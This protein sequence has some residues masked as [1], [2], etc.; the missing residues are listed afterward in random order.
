[1]RLA[2]EARLALQRDAPNAE[3]LLGSVP[4]TLRREPGL[5]L[6]HARWLRRA[7]RTTDALALWQRAG[8]AAQRD[9]SAD[10]LSGFW[11]ERN[12]LARRLL[13]DSAAT[14]A[15]ALASQH[16]DVAADQV[17][18]AEFLAGFIALRRLK[19]PAAA[20]RHFSVLAASSKAAITQAR[21]HYWLARA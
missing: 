12:L 8:E 5:V 13:R 2:A 20:Q 10:E 7:D 1:H 6:D 21:A 15:Y 3:A 11:T 4:A 19:D 14:K 18:D 17:L 16:G 9:A